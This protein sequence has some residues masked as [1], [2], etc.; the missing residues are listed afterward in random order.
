MTKDKTCKNSD[1]MVDMK[2]VPDVSTKEV[3]KT[4]GGSSSIKLEGKDITVKL[5]NRE[6]ALHTDQQII[7]MEVSDKKSAGIPGG[8]KQVSV[9]TERTEEKPVKVELLDD[10]EVNVKIIREVPFCEQEVIKSEGSDEKKEK[11]KKK[12][13]KKSKKERKKEKKARKE[14]KKV[15]KK[16]KRE[17]KQLE[18]SKKRKIIEPE[19]QAAKAAPGDPPKLKPLPTEEDVFYQSNVVRYD[20]PPNRDFT[21]FQNVEPKYQLEDTNV[22]EMS[23]WKTRRCVG[24][25]LDY[26]KEQ[27]AKGLD[28]DVPYEGQEVIK[29]PDPPKRFT[30]KLRRRLHGRNRSG[31]GGRDAGYQARKPQDEYVNLLS[32]F[33]H[34]KVGIG[35]F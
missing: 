9:K 6:C 33:M 1:G 13:D 5:E 2:Y 12:K 18:T 8:G 4:E 29:A 19:T 21:D 35:Y 28:L 22:D 11:K 26:V 34:N 30:P 23:P 24:P 27:K 25:I 15:A 31:R 32:G 17:Q 14:A 10:V 3:I 20:C 7:K 16:R